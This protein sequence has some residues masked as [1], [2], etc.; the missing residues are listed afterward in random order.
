MRRE[1]IAVGFVAKSLLAGVLALGLVILGLLAAD[2]PLHQRL[3]HHGGAD[4]GG[5]VLCL[6]V[7]G[8]VNAASVAT[9]LAVF[10]FSLLG[11]VVLLGS[12]S[13][14]ESEHLLPPGRAPPHFSSV[15]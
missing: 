2:G 14:P 12:P 6:F 8:H 3:H 10:T 1:R 7:Q 9:V 4:A 11:A 5:C 15:S 13:L